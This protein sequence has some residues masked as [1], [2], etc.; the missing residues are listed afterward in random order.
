MTIITNEGS[1]VYDVYAKDDKKYIGVE[2][3]I[4][5]LG[6]KSGAIHHATQGEIADIF[7]I[8]SPE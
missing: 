8:I 3:F 4:Y 6:R 5:Y 1:F 7:H 2:I